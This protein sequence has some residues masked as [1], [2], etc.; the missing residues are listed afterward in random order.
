SLASGTEIAAP[1]N[2][3]LNARITIMFCSNATGSHKLPLL[4]FG[5]AVGIAT[6]VGASVFNDG[7]RNI[8]AMM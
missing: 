4:T 2:Q 5:K 1:K 3:I 7:Y 8:L 6:F